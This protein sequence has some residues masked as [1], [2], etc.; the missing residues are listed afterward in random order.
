MASGWRAD[1]RLRCQREGGPLFSFS[2]TPS[3][4]FQVF[5]QLIFIA[6]KFI[7]KEKDLCGGGSL[8]SGGNGGPVSHS[9]P[10][11]TWVWGSTAAVR[12]FPA[13]ADPCLPWGPPVAAAPSV[14]SP[15][16]MPHCFSTPP[17]PA[18]FPMCGD[19]WENRTRC[20]EP[21]ALGRLWGDGGA[22]GARSAA[23]RAGSGVP[24]RGRPRGAE[25]RAA[26]TSLCS[27]P[28][29]GRLLVSAKHLLRFGAL[30]STGVPC[31]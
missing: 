24:L 9:I 2:F 18:C 20:S 8:E 1:V 26:G 11:R 15:P 6:Y 5:H 28:P 25:H 27:R 30:R 3:D 7:K 14:S 31:T 12:R 22:W 23:R 21:G 10:T 29:W 4:I 19:S 16:R 13:A 17:P